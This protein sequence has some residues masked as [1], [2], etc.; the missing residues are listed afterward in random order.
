[1]CMRSVNAILNLFASVRKTDEYISFSVP[2][3]TI[4]CIFINN[5]PYISEFFIVANMNLM[6]T[7]NEEA[8]KINVVE[9]RKELFCLIRLTKTSNVSTE[10][11][12]WDIEQFSIDTSDKTYRFDDA[13][14]PTVNYRKIVEV[15]NIE[16]TE[17][18]RGDYALKLL[19]RTS[20]NDP[21]D[22]QSIV[23]LTVI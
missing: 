21:W 8:K 17:N 2:F 15:Q 5:V 23:R 3:D 11:V 1:M 13:C 12:S 18:Y 19:V 20:E 10:R 14:V 6:G 16:L 9:N 22:V 7:T 4:K